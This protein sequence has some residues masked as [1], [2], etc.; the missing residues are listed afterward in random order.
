MSDLREALSA[1]KNKNGK[2]LDGKEVK[3]EKA[4]GGAASRA[5]EKERVRDWD[6]D[7]S[8]KVRDL[9]EQV[10]KAKADTAYAKPTLPMPRLTLPAPP[11]VQ[12]RLS[13]R[14]STPSPVL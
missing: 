11:S 2:K 7:H 9:R 12:P 13:R 6:W 10:A 5:A 14:L 4:G 8:R 3:V 1:I